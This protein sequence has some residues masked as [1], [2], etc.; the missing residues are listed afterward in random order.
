[1]VEFC[2]NKLEEKITELSN[3]RKIFE[4]KTSSY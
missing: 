1:M 4:T 3:T 2:Q